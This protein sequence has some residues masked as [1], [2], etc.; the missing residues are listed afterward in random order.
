MT[1]VGVLGATGAV[2]QRFVQLLAGHETF[3]LSVV[4]ASPDSAGETYRDAANWG[5]DTPVPE[6]I[7]ELPVQ[8]TTPAAIP[9]DTA[10]LFSALPSDVGAEVEPALCEAGFVVS[11]NASNERRAGDVPLVVPEV[12]A[13]HLGLIDVQRDARGWDGALVK[14]PNCSTI[15]MVPTLAA[16]TEFGL[17]R[18]HV[19]TLQAVS[20]AG[21]SGVTSMEI[22]DNVVPHI[23]GEERKME[24]ESRKLL[25]EF[26]GAEVQ[27]HDAVVSASCNRVPTLDG[28]LENVFVE[29][30]DH[31]APADVAAAFEDAPTLDL[32][33]APDPLI[34]TFTAPERPQPRL[35]RMRGDGMAIAAGG[36]QTTDT[37][38]QY[39][40]LAHNTIRGAAGASILNGELLAREGWV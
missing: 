39:N 8:P 12:N 16:L 9:D 2:G 7:A 1:T 4:T 24:T 18:V 5:L 29:T 13:D 35:D 25:G 3:E 26:T 37:G 14:N 19:A 38:I 30:S 31:P 15:T 40:C 20:G 33:S 36:I 11:S 21:Y 17:D 27:H 28:H 23:G 6:S 10:L 34:E 22:L 32:P